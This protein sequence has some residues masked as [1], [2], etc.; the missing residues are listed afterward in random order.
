LAIKNRV[1]IVGSTAFIFL[2]RRRAPALKAAIDLADLSLVQSIGG[3][4]VPKWNETAQEWYARHN[5][6]VRDGKRSGSCYMHRF[7]LGITDPNIQVDHVDHRGL[8]NRRLNLRRAN[9]SNN[10][11]NRE[12]SQPNCKSGHRN[13]YWN[14]R[15][16]QW[17]VWVVCNG[18]R[19][20]AGY[21]H[22]SHLRE[23]VATAVALRT[24]AEAEMRPWQ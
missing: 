14:A 16:N 3:S 1:E 20:Y 19:F 13:V 17:M 21:F 7:I 8:N 11:F 23:A 9:Y 12:G 10:Q 4:W 15:E 5:G 2:K 22:K 24:K 6:F 18:K